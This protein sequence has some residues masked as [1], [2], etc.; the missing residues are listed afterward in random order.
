MFYFPCFVIFVSWK[1]GFSFSEPSFFW[2]FFLTLFLFFHPPSDVSKKKCFEKIGKTSSVSSLPVFS[3]LLSRYSKKH[4]VCIQISLFFMFEILFE[5]LLSLQCK[6]QTNQ[7]TKLRFCSVFF[8][9]FTL[10]KHFPSFSFITFFF[11]HFF[12]L[13]LLL[14]SPFSSLS[15]LRSFFVSLSQCFYLMFFLNLFLHRR[16]WVSPWDLSFFSFLLSVKIVL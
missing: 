15:F 10:K 2:F 6:P 12:S 9:C 5:N 14:F 13:S 7:P 4:I 8:F 3:S 11:D 1:M 16:F